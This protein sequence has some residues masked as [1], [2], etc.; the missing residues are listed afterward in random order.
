VILLCTPV[1]RWCRE[2]GNCTL[3]VVTRQLVQVLDQRVSYFRH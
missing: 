3:Q 1:A 2:H